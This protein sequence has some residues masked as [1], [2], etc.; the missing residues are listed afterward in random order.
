MFL[1]HFLIVKKMLEYSKG[2]VHLEYFGPII[3]TMTLT[4]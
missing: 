1:D 4:L 2:L 3:Q